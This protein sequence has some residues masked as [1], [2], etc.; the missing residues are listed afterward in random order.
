MPGERWTGDTLLHEQALPGRVNADECWPDAPR[1][2][3]ATRPAEP[4]AARSGAERVLE[5]A[6]K[7]GTYGIHPTDFDA[8]R[9]VD[10]GKPI[11]RLAARID[12]LRD[13][14]HWF[15]TRRHRDR[16]VTYVL[17]RDAAAVEL[18]LSRAGEPEPE[19]LFEPPPA[20]PLNALHDWDDAA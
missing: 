19:R 11:R 16:T 20:P 5:L 4:I 8:G 1:G 18:V 2:V 12:E 15:D 10:G 17:V 9:V 7:R 3:S 6:R 14:G 13:Q